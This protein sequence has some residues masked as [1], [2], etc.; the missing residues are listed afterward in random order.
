VISVGK[1]TA[2]VNAIAQVRARWDASNMPSFP[3]T[4]AQEVFLPTDVKQLL[5]IPEE[6]S[7]RFFLQQNPQLKDRDLVLYL[8]SQVPKIARDD[9]DR[10]QQLAS[11]ARWLS[12][13]LDDDHCRARSARAMGHTLQ[14]KGKL[15]ESLVEYEKALDLFTKLKLESEVGI[16][17]S[18][19]LQPL[20]LLGNYEEARLREE[21]ARKIFKAEGDELRLA[22][23]DANLGNILHRQ[24][25]FEEALVLYGRAEQALHRFDAADDLAVVLNNL[26]VCYINLG[27]FPNALEA[28]RRL[29][30]Y[31][32]QQHLPM[33]TVQA[34]YNIAYLHY[35]KGEHHQAI[36]LYQ[37]TRI[38]C[39]G[40]G[41]P[42]HMALCDL[43]RAEIYLHLNEHKECARLAQDSAA[44]FQSLEMNYEAAKAYTFLG[45]AA[46]HQTDF[47]TSLELFGKA[48]ELFLIEKNW[49]WPAIVDF[50]RA[51]AL[52]RSGRLSEALKCVGDAQNVLSH[53]PLKDKAA[54]AELLRSQLHREL[55]DPVAAQ[56]W[57]ESAL[58]RIERSEIPDMR[59]LAWLVLGRA[60]ESQSDQS[61]AHRQRERAEVTAGSGTDGGRREQARPPLFK[62]TDTVYRQLISA[63]LRLPR[64][65]L[66]QKP[67]LS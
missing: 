16:T 2:R 66:T 1:G 49:I 17:L 27:D 10:A 29:R 25:R 54:L 60:R 65:G 32:E 58:E 26:A 38:L 51:T 12:G 57:S 40:A 4:E 21:R 46:C 35:L 11:L 41:D 56:Y 28:Y 64:A 13:I 45:L 67:R 42:Y 22:R 31:S 33:L 37:K 55:G 30:F 53:S 19:S 43:D 44:Q 8:A 36:E 5:E 34:D 50:Y 18:G 47:L 24:D 52:Y 48:R 20:I 63:A 59:Y 6:S 7:R 3:P 14:L 9:A 62:T 23:L 39:A 15:R 61:D